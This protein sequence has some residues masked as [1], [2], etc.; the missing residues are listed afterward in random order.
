MRWVSGVARARLSSLSTH[1]RR[2]HRH[3]RLPRR[4]RRLRRGAAPA[5]E[6]HQRRRQGRQD[7][8]HPRAERLRQEARAARLQPRRRLGPRR[9]RQHPRC[10]AVRVHRVSRRAP[11]GAARTRRE[12]RRPALSRERPLRLQHRFL[13]L[14]LQRRHRRVHRA[15]PPL[16]P[17]AG[18]VQLARAR[19]RGLPGWPE[20]VLV[21]RPEPDGGDHAP[22]CFNHSARPSR[23]SR[24]RTHRRP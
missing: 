11:A 10:R 5:R 21:P 15:R 14:P 4:L 18:D 8:H 19:P 17:D 13:W 20:P 24:S 7:R 23:S 9:H 3:P 2:P 6:G 22:W 1:R 12:R 16:R